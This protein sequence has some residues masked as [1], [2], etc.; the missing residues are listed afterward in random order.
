MNPTTP[1][2]PPMPHPDVSVIICSYNRADWLREAIESL[3]D[4][5]TAGFSYEIL[6]VDNASTDHTAAVL[7]EMA[8]QRPD[9]L[10]HV[11]ESEP[12]V[13]FARNRGVHE[14]KG[15]WIAFFDDD[16]LAEPDWLLQLLKAAQKYDVKCVG[17][18]VK[19]KFHPGKER[20]LRHWVRVTLGCTEGMQEQLYDGKRVPTTGNML[21]HKEIFETIG[22]FRTD[23]VEGGEDTDLYHR[24]RTAGYKAYH[25]PKALAHHQIPPFRIEPNYLRSTSMRMGSHIARRELEQRGRFR[26]S[27]GTLARLGQ[28]LLVHL[29]KLIL[30]KLG[31]DPEAILERKCY[32]WMW[33]GYFAAAFR[34]LFRGQEQANPLSFRQERQLA[35]ERH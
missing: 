20:D 11:I 2:Q 24:S 25:A 30:A 10:R 15:E 7:A 5:E 23:L 26:F 18:A 27:I 16:E 33:K 29:P 28:T 35:S 4:L 9:K 3:F 17:G 21:I 32:W 19:L 31:A 22:L 34:L 12:G 14:S 6:V 8:Q 13:S 1:S